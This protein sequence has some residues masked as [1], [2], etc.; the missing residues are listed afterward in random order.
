MKIAFCWRS[1]K[2]RHANKNK[3]HRQLGRIRD[4]RKIRRRLILASQSE[5]NPGEV[6]VYRCPHC[7]GWHVG[8]RIGARATKRAKGD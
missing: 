1:G 7:D 4:G 3:A 2:V 8:H 5:S 6:H